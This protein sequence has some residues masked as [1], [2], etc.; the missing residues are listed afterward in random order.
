M[1]VTWKEHRGDTAATMSAQPYRFEDIP[2]LSR[3]EVDAMQELSRVLP[4]PE[5]FRQL[6]RA[7]GITLQ[8]L[9]RPEASL[10]SRA[11]SSTAPSSKSPETTAD[12]LGM[13]V[14]M[15]GG[16]SGAPSSVDE[17]VHIRRHG[18]AE[19]DPWDGGPHSVRV[20][21]GLGQPDLRA[22]FEMPLAAVR[23]IVGAVVDVAPERL[24]A[25]DLISTVEKG[26]LAFFAERIAAGVSERSQLL[27]PW[28]P[29]T[30]LDVASENA[31]L[32]WGNGGKKDWY[33]VSGVLVVAELSLPFRLAVPWRALSN[34]RK[35]GQIS[36]GDQMGRRS[37]SDHWFRTLGSYPV[38]FR[39]RLG[40]AA[41]TLG[42]IERLEPT[43]ILL[44]DT[45]N[46]QWDG[47]HLS[48]ELPLAHSQ[49]GLVRLQTQ[50]EDDAET[51]RVRIESIVPGRHAEESE[52]KIMNDTSQNTGPDPESTH[53]GDTAPGDTSGAGRQVAEETPVT[54]RV[55][56]GRI[57]L[58][59]REL[60]QLSPGSVIEMGRDPSAPVS[61]V[62]EDRVIGVGDLVKVDGELGVRIAE[63]T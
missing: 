60:A 35:S 28:M 13:T 38:E 58:T 3:T 54:V 46:F 24:G 18:P 15:Q 47:Q 17:F 41:L 44:F 43:D 50:I 11:A 29:I 16:L 42:D 4:G 40:A 19:S 22:V 21:Y 57:R 59:L 26:V 51:L 30:V 52:A 5:A 39:G 53:P 1:V 49:D 20:H 27:A 25:S 8:R 14:P 23:S 32:D 36:A 55:E 34:A 63:L 9:Q 62:V 45:G 2:E 56:L 48:G 7:V 31:P 12:T 10:A 33:T 61:L 6:R 37:R